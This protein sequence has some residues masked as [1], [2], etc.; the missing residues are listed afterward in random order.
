MDNYMKLEFMA[1]SENESFARS[2][3]AGFALSL[4]PSLSEL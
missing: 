4:N 2:V 1:K 3:V